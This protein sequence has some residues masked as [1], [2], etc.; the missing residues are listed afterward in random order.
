MD[1]YLLDRIEFNEINNNECEIKI[2]ASSSNK[3][4]KIE[5]YIKFS[6]KIK[7]KEF[8]AALRM[9]V[10]SIEKVLNGEKI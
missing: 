4:N 1:E 2:Y 5:R 6:K 10:Y 8:N 3:S 9:L 7:L